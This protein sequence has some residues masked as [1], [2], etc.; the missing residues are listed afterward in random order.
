MW[1]SCEQDVRGE[2]INKGLGDS[3]LMSRSLQIRFNAQ[4]FLA[5]RDS[6]RKQLHFLYHIILAL[7]PQ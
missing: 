4:C 5:S 1:A 3:F 7:L 2:L 6:A